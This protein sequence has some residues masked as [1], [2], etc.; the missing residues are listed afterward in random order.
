MVFQQSV[1][2]ATNEYETNG[3]YKTADT[4]AKHVLSAAAPHAF[5]QDTTVWTN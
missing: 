4:F 1:L 5:L 2:S 3:M